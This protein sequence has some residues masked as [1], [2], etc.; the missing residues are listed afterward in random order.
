[1]FHKCNLNGYAYDDDDAAADNDDDHNDA[2]NDPVGLIIV[3]M[4][5]QQAKKIDKLSKNDISDPLGVMVHNYIKLAGVQATP[6]R[7]IATLLSNEVKY[8][9][10]ILSNMTDLLQRNRRQ[11][12]VFMFEATLD[13]HQRG[14]K[15]DVHEQNCLQLLETVL[16]DIS[17]NIIR[18]TLKKKIK[19][20]AQE[21]HAAFC[22]ADLD[23]HKADKIIVDRLN[24]LKQQ[25][26]HQINDK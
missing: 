19:S 21:F 26:Q 23:L 13:C 20:M 16:K 14:I 25:L 3:A 10:K 1:M 6:E 4:Q 8:D 15:S 24:V 11:A 22:N 18:S 17:Y 7:R 5:K 12:I 2:D 9:P